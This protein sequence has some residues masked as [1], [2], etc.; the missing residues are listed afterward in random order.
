MNRIEFPR[1]GADGKKYTKEDIQQW[2]RDTVE[3]GIE[4]RL[5]DLHHRTTIE[6]QR[7]FIQE[8][9]DNLGTLLIGEPA[10]LEVIKDS[11]HNDYAIISSADVYKPHKAKG[12][13]VVHS[14]SEALLSAMNFDNYRKNELVELSCKLNIKVC[15]YCNHNYTLYIDDKRKTWSKGLFQFDHFYNKA[16]YPYLSM[17]LYNLIPSCS[18]CNH[19]KTTTSLNLRYNPYYRGISKEFRFEVDDNIQLRSGIKGADKIQIKIRKTPNGQGIDELKDEL[20][21]EEQYGRHKDIVQE[22]YDKVYNEKYYRDML[23]CIPNSAEFI[24]QWIGIP[25]SEEDIDKQPL[26]KFRQDI[27]KQARQEYARG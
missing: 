16:T 19:Q 11:L 22:I 18:L 27:L 10:E 4:K 23:A 25:M 13:K 26:T 21:L 2:Y 15:P 12:E 1:I 24:N 20:H 5:K 3:S 17:S 14:F 7:S 8:L 6:D 9:I